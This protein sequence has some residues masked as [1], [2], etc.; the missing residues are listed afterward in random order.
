MRPVLTAATVIDSFPDQRA[1]TLGADSNRDAYDCPGDWSGPEEVYRFTVGDAGAFVAEVS[2]TAATLLL[3]GDGGCITQGSKIG[4]WLEPGAY[5]VVVEA[6]SAG[7]FELRLNHMHVGHFTAEG[8]AP[9]FA[10]HAVWAFAV[11]WSQGHT[12][13]FQYATTDFSLHS[14]N[15]R[16]W[17]WDMLTG[18]LKFHLYVAH[19]DGSSSADDPGLAVRFSN[20]PES[21]QSSIGM[22]RTAESYN[23]DFGYSHRLDGIEPGFN[24]QVRRRDIV[25][26]P[27]RGSRPDFVAQYGYTGESWG[28]PSVDD[29]VSTEVVDLMHSGA[30]SFFYYPDETWLGSSPFSADVL[31]PVCGDQICSPGEEIECPGDCPVCG[32]VPAE[33]GLVDDGACFER[34]GPDQYWRQET[35]IGHGGSLFWTNGFESEQP[36]NWARWTVA[37]EASGTYRVETA[38]LPEF[39]QSRRAPWA[40]TDANGRKALTV[41]LSSDTEWVALGEFTFEGGR[42][43]PVEVYDNSGDLD[44]EPRRIMADALRITPVQ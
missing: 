26:H 23:G 10:R 43:Y 24:D 2:G 5:T 28:C 40:V 12:E 15:R 4:T 19:G 35:G 1:G 8:M 32:V 13:R 41:D 30:L 37:V 38:V 21:H 36:S 31:G 20:I 3:L 27:S 44:G 6:A 11:G 22:L 18:E 16:Q 39:A 33:G 9:E 42:P 17:I 25:M 7:G 29:G 34:F 14:R